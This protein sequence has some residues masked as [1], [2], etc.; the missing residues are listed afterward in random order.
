MVMALAR[1]NDYQASGLWAVKASIALNNSSVISPPSTAA[2][3][4]LGFGD[5]EVEPRFSSSPTQKQPFVHVAPAP[6]SPESVTPTIEHIPFTLP[7]HMRGSPSLE[8]CSVSSSESQSSP[9]VVGVGHRHNTFL[10]VDDNRINLQVRD[11]E[12]LCF[13]KNYDLLTTS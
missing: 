3:T 2:T 9:S 11:L 4:P 7:F 5:E 1:W 13:C 12:W 10:L 6:D 8:T